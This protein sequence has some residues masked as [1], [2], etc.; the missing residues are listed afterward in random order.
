MRAIVSFRLPFRICTYFSVSNGV[1]LELQTCKMF[2]VE[3]KCTTSFHVLCSRGCEL[4]LLCHRDAQ[5]FFFFFGQRERDSS[6][7]S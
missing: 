1:V 7:C 2:V 4:L 3:F 6:F 5:F